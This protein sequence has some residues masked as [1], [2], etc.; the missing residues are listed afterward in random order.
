V[1]QVIYRYLDCGILYT[2][3]ARVKCKDCGHEYLLAF[4]CKRRHFCPSCHQKRV[5]EF[6]EWLCEGVLKVVPHQHFTFSIPKIL[7]RYFLYDRELLRELSH[8]PWGSF[9]PLL[10][11][12]VPDPDASPGA[13]I[14]TQTFGDFL[15][16]KPHCHLLCTDKSFFGSG[17]FKVAPALDTGSLEK[18]FQPKV[19]KMLTNSG[20]VPAR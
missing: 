12:T 2:G 6:G 8:C 18:L 7:K 3:F 14:A 5:V 16:F 19:L 10:L 9:V 20:F 11:A 4:S 1:K 13:V 15:N 17:M